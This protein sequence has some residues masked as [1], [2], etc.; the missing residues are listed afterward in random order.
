MTSFLK[1][2]LL[3]IITLAT[4]IFS[5]Q[6]VS[7]DCNETECNNSLAIA[8]NGSQPETINN[9]FLFFKIKFKKQNYFLGTKSIQTP[10]ATV[11]PISL[12][13]NLAN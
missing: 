5:S 10:A 12:I 2:R 9:N 3:V 7:V 8:P 11:C 13:A 6:L 4:L 1:K